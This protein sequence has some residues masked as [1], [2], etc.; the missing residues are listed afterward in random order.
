MVGLKR[1]CDWELSSD[2]KGGQLKSA[3]TRLILPA[4][5]TVHLLRFQFADAD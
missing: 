3:I 4:V 2:L 1:N 5:M